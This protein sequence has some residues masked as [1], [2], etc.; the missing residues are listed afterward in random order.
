MSKSTLSFKFSPIHLSG[1][2]IELYDNVVEK[3]RAPVE[4]PNS[5]SSAGNQHSTGVVM[6]GALCPVKDREEHKMMLWSS[7]KLDIRAQKEAVEF[8]PQWVATLH[9][10]QLYIC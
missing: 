9:N 3:A 4:D 6:V 1:N 10:N 5:L 7:C 2:K 8:E